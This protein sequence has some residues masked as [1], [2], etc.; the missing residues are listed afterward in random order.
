VRD[1]R[2]V[3]DVL[4]LGAGVIGLTTAVT[5]AEAGH[6]VRVWSR[7]EL[8]DT[9]SAVAGAIWG[10]GPG[11]L[12][13]AERVAAWSEVTL[14]VL[15]ELAADPDSGVRLATG[16]EATRDEVL[17]PAEGAVPCEPPPGYRVAHRVTAPVVD[18]PRHLAHL[19][20][21]FAAAGGVTERR[22][23]RALSDAVG[24]APVLV[25]CL[26]VA[27]HQVVP[28]ERVRP[29]RGQHVVVA[30]P[31]LDGF[32]VQR[33]DEPVWASF[34][35]HGDRVVLGGVAEPDVWD[36]VPDPRTAVAIV[37]RCAE[38]EPALA[39]AP[40]LAH[41]VGLRP[42]RP[43]VRLA[44]TDLDGAR[45]IHNYGHGGIGVTLSWGCA[46]EVATLV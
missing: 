19:A 8:A 10:R 18:M 29:V 25:N 46:R 35:A 3:T 17:P 41:Q 1:G 26:G 16:V 38:V 32:F 40:V 36:R 44:A 4:V 27:A 22:A 7:D 23:V 33:T 15:T 21:R 31:G 14:A 11:A 9:T 24:V 13:P 20:A 6:R 30:N 5:L 37:A 42:Y 45:V 12:G 43:E 2:R 34:F 39:D 28:D